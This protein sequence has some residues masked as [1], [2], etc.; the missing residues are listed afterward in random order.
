LQQFGR[1]GT[2]AHRC[3]RGEDDRP[4]VPRWQ[5]THL[6]ADIEF[7]TPLVERARLV[8]ASRYLV[9]PLLAKLRGN[10]QACGQARLTVRFEDGRS[11]ERARV[12][13]FPV[14]DEERVVRAMDQLLAGMNW[15]AAAT[16]MTISLTQIQDAIA[17]QLTLFP[18]QDERATKLREVQRYLAARFGPSFVSGR[19]R[20]A[21]MA[22]PGAPLPEWRVS[23][24]NREKT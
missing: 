18:L 4:V 8:A 17:E 3:A 16:A 20:Q 19:L 14:A 11:Q 13:L 5:A 1:A 23:W 2:L 22:Q 7:E 24:R 10:L 9:S 12:F 6:A 15:Q 21:E